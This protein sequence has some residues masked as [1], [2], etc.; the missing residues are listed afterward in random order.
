MLV[1]RDLHMS[2]WPRPSACATWVF[3]NCIYIYM[4]AMYS[5]LTLEHR[6]LMFSSMGGGS[7][8]LS[9]NVSSRCSKVNFKSI[10]NFER[11]VYINTC[12]EML[13]RTCGT[14]ICFNS[15]TL[16]WWGMV[17]TRR[18]G[19]IR[20]CLTNHDLQQIPYI[21]HLQKSSVRTS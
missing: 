6:G 9:N 1:T 16:Q 11:T 15:W 12:S 17:Y 3:R 21:P 5:L 10:L 13:V 20:V 18:T 2:N 19:V 4:S 7:H 14:P 8:P